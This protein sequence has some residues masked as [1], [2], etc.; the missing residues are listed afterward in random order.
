MDMSAADLTVATL[1]EQPELGE[2]LR[3]SGLHG[4]D[5]WPPFFAGDA[6]NAQYWPLL[7]EMFPAQQVLLLDRGAIV[8]AGHS[9]PLCWDGT[10]PGL[11]AGWDAA[12]EQG[13]RDHD[14]GPPPTALSALAV[15][16]AKARRGQGLSVPVLQAL[17]TI[18]A[19]DGLPALIVPIRPTWK[20]RYPLTPFA[21][22]VQ[23]TQADGLPFDPWLRA[24]VRLGAEVLSVAPRSM[25]MTGA[26][27]E[28]ERWTG[29]AFPDSG[30]YVVPGALQPITIDTAADLGRYEDPNLWLLHRVPP[31]AAA[32]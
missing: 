17:V 26:M 19:R 9:I 3:Q 25:V 23:W 7:E 4:P 6:A 1:A 27:G 16:V 32:R 22:Y 5:A 11:P 8:A 21:R 14:E 12:I 24:H 30:Q 2:R 18:A 15:V 20:H 29:L 10:V 31:R 28:W 13:F